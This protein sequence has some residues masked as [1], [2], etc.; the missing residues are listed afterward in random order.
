MVGKLH[1]LM[2]AS[3]LFYLALHSPAFG[4]V[5]YFID[6]HSQVDDQ[7]EIDTIVK[8]MDAANVRM[9]ILAA[10]G[11]R[12]WRD[13]ANLRFTYTGRIIPAVRTKGGAYKRN[14]KRYYERLDEQLQDEKF[15][16]MAEVL[17]YHAKK[18]NKAPE[19]VVYPK[20]RRV[21]AALS[22]ALKRGWPFVIHIEFASLNA[23]RRSRF[24]KSMKKMLVKYEDHPFALIHMGQLEAKDVKTLIEAH[25]N[26]YFMTSHSDPI[27]VA[28]S[29][30][31]WV[32][33]FEGSRFKKEWKALFI[34]HS[35]KFIFALDNV[36][37]HHWLDEYQKKM[38]YWEEALMQLPD[39]VANTIAHKNAERLWS[40]K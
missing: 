28:R 2:A 23:R 1:L 24:M 39:N 22:P 11:L 37:E 32:K 16:A 33:L 7:V 12:D 4:D 5:T 6:A 14:S 34:K 3:S 20:D 9:T 31:P 25:K 10:R 17:L 40:I 19:V 36:W 26:L 35:D 15:A 18:G 27:T 29:R 21:R 38:K 13:I 30:Q 8:Q